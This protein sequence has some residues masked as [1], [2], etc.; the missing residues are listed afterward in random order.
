M[1][2]TF[3]ITGISRGLGL[4]LTRHF[5]EK[6]YKVIGLSRTK[7]EALGRLIDKYPELLEWHQ[8]DLERLCQ[9]EESIK[10]VVDL[11]KVSID[12]F[13]DNAAILYKDLIHK[14]RGKELSHMFCINTVIPIILTKMIVNNFLRFKKPGCIIHMSSICAHRAFNGLSMMGAT[15]AAIE[16]FS[17]DTA[18]EYGRFGIRSNTV[19]AGLLEIGMRST[20]N[21]RLTDNLKSMTAMRKLVDTQ[22]IVSIIDYL[23]SDDSHCITG[24]NIH[25][26]AGIV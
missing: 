13:I 12:V 26:N 11:D 2:K 1:M 10:H 5:L 23:V 21:E 17:R 8:F 24:E 3:F 25:I 6:G 20:V 15:K 19:V 9:D 4:E 14:I 16:A 7:S 18:Y 22:S